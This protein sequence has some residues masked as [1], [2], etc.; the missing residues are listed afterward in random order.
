M[1]WLALTTALALAGCGPSVAINTFCQSYTVV[2]FSA[3][4]P[5][6]DPK[7]R[8]ETAANEFDT[9]LTIA[10]VRSANAAYRGACGTK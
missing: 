4:Y 1:R 8:E 7:R 10:Q 3:Q 6:G 2:T 9:D 5:P